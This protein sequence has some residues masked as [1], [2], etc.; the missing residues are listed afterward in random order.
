METLKVSNRT[1]PP[2]GNEAT[3]QNDSVQRSKQTVTDQK[4]LLTLVC[5]HF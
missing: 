5:G 2:S 4:Q 1:T 3:V